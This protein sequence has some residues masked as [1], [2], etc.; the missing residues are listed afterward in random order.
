M[1]AQGPFWKESIL[2]KVCIY[3]LLTF[4][5]FIFYVHSFSIMLVKSF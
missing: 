4:F 3:L 1:R 5:M 2:Q